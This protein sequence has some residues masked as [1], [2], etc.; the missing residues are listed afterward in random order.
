MQD[1]SPEE[2]VPSW[3]CLGFR[4]RDFPNN[5]HLSLY[6]NLLKILCDCLPIIKIKF[7]YLKKCATGRLYLMPL[8]KCF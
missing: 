7:S 8:Y 5:S 2:Q 3:R 6:V 4:R 1:T